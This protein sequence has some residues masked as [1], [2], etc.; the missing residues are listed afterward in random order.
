[1]SEKGSKF[2]FNT[3]APVYGLFFDFQVRKYR[4]VIHENKSLFNRYEKVLD[5]GC[6]TGA[7]CFVLDE[8][9][10]G[11]TGVDPA[12]KM[13]RIAKHKNK[14]NNNAFIQSDILKRL[15][16]EDKA[17]DISI[18][19]FVAHG[20]KVDD[21]IKMYDEMSRLTKNKIIFYDYNTKRSMLSDIIEWLENGDYFNFIKYAEKE[22]ND[23]FKDVEIINVDTMASL[24]VCTPNGK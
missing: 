12:E 5:I 4:K 11:V 7:M 13:L 2:L 19:S 18:A 23:Y 22:M 16:F 6:G 10:M 15:P 1:M 17:F 9:Q 14:L 3:I 21:R 24:Y 8:L 20:M